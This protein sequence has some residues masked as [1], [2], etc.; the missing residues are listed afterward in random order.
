MARISAQWKQL[1]F[2]ASDT[3]GSSSIAS[4]VCS[5]VIIWAFIAAAYLYLCDAASAKSWSWFFPLS[6]APFLLCFHYFVHM[7]IFFPLYSTIFFCIYLV[8]GFIRKVSCLCFRWFCEFLRYFAYSCFLEDP[9]GGSNKTTSKRGLGMV[10]RVWR[11]GI[12]KEE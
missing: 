3:Y 10:K 9:E 12:L 11:R 8:H 1:L 7:N 5:A 6:L 2:H 4:S